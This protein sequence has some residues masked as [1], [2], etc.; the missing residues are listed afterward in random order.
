MKEISIKLQCSENKVDYWID[1]HNISK[2]SRS[3]ASYYGYWRPRSNGKEI[4]V[5]SLGKQ[6]VLDQVKDLYLQKG[7]SAKEV[8]EFFGKS[9]SSVYDFMRNNG[10]ERRKT[11]D[12]NNFIF[13]R[14]QL[15][16]NIK[17]NLNRK[18]EKL[19]V[20]GIML[21]WAEGG[22][23]VCRNN[24]QWRGN[25]VNF[26][27][28]DPKMIK[29]FLRFLRKICGVDERRLRVHFYCYVN[30]D[31]DYLKNYWQETT[32]IPLTQFIKPYVRQDFLLEKK[33]KMKYGLV[34]IVYSDTKL[35]LQIMDWINEYV[36]E[37][38]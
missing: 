2:R 1:K 30:Q 24:G 3:E 6:F 22:K 21:Y 29:V 35:F 15:S 38:Q 33:D 11:A 10:L 14:K 8:G 5:F 4:P 26:A 9:T 37:Q 32:R 27:N 19:K 25:S 16:F 7:Y 20:A 34:H 28:S 17:K 31:V 23:E 13:K 18:E 12:T 36:G